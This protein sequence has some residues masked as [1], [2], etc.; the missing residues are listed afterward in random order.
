[1]ANKSTAELQPALEAVCAGDPRAMGEAQGRALRSKIHGALRSLKRLEAFRLERPWFLPHAAFLRLAERTAT[2]ALGPALA[3]LDPAMRDRLEGMATGAELRPG[4]LYLLNAMEALLAS[5]AGRTG[6]PS[7]GACS[8]VAVR[9]GRSATGEPIIV[10]NFDYLPIIQPF[11]TIRESRPR[12]GRRSLDFTVAPLAGTVDGIN[13][14]GLCITF[15]YAFA[16]DRAEP[17]PLVSMAIADALASCASVAEAADRIAAR[18][19]WGAG[20]LVLGD[21]AGDL[22]VLE[23]SNTR[24]A[25][26]RQPPG[27]DVLAV[28]NVCAADALAS[29]QVSP[30][31]V[32]AGRVPAALAGRPILEPHAARARR[33]EELLSARTAFDPDDLARLMAD[34]GL[35]GEPDASSP[36]VHTDYWGTTACLQFLP[37]ARR[38]CISY[39]SAC[40]ARF[41]DFA[42]EAR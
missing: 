26:R 41:H 8:A 16:T 19:R 20:I 30:T 27:S 39:G 38:L 25:L 3:R 17:A 42:L 22:A 31:A 5:L 1:M 14:D 9:R 12:D 36:C 35:S 21:A 7:P 2:R 28:T 29:V 40:R 13:E 24:S 10:K 4:S 6:T 15:N 23:L 34:H 33:I 11:Y 37:V 32:F 18:P